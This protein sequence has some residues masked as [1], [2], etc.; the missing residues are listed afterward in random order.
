MTIQA[1]RHGGRRT[2]LALFAL[3]S[4]SLA[5]RVNAQT[6]SVGPYQPSAPPLNASA[7]YQDDYAAA[8]NGYSQSYGGSQQYGQEYN[9][10]QSYA[11]QSFQGVPLNDASQFNDQAY[12]Y[13]AFSQ[14]Y[15][16]GETLDPQN[17]DRT[18]YPGAQ[19]AKGPSKSTEQPEPR[20]R[21][22]RSAGEIWSALLFGSSPNKSRADSQYA[23]ESTRPQLI[24][25]HQHGNADELELNPI[26]RF[27][28][29]SWLI[30]NSDSRRYANEYADSPYASNAQ[31]ANEYPDDSQPY[32]DRFFSGNGYPLDASNFGAQ[33]FAEG[34]GNAGDYS[35]PYFPGLQQGVDQMNADLQTMRQDVSRHVR[36]YSSRLADNIE[37]QRKRAAQSL[38]TAQRDASRSLRTAQRNTTAAIQTAQRDAARAVNQG[39]RKIARE[40]ARV[41]Q[42]AQKAMQ[43]VANA[44]PNPQRPS[45]AR[46]RTLG[47]SDPRATPRR[48]NAVVA[49]E[50]GAAP[51]AQNEEVDSR[52]RRLEE[53][54][55]ILAAKR[56]EE[57]SRRIRQTNA[58][59]TMENTPANRTVNEAPLEFNAARA[60]RPKIRQAS[61]D[62]PS[63]RVPQNQA[64]TR[65]HA[66]KISDNIYLSSDL[67]ELP[68]PGAQTAN[69]SQS[70]PR[71][72][73]ARA[74][75]PVAKKEPQKL[76]TYNSDLDEEKESTPEPLKQSRQ[77]SNVE[78]T[79]IQ[80]IRSLQEESEQNVLR[81]SADFIDPR[82]L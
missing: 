75:T 47:K 82:D 42:D 14:N 9:V 35:E 15:Y 55:A 39:Q 72:P 79:P 37:S 63:Q 29:F 80:N 8:P 45:A 32:D 24:R 13:G 73:S 70:N 77:K 46:Q 7:N 30:G 1:L 58:L 78:P 60:N 50:H 2:I 26:L 10:E 27:F 31:F 53:L 23:A 38:Q 59:T 12:D 21:S 17:V 41:N 71:K 40:V 3:I 44:M 69:S 20:A 74:K 34:Y 11:G 51:L 52:R 64:P 18:F 62:E 76:P 36:D 25:H 6:V 4:L 33:G 16:P 28:T 49:N 65:P 68:Q 43:N 81:S 48:A 67:V 56:P 66:V 19:A 5:T 57:Y 61:H 54:N 22:R